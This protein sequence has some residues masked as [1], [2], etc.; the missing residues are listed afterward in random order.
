MID[1]TKVRISISLLR[2]SLSELVCVF[3]IKIIGS[4]GQVFMMLNQQNG[5]ILAMKEIVIPENSPG[6]AD[7]LSKSFENE[8]NLLSKLNHKNIINYF[9]CNRSKNS[10]EIF[11]EYLPGGS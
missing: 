6:N 1:F 4:F 7:L 8:V 2:G 5:K 3:F 10:L 9:K 11:M